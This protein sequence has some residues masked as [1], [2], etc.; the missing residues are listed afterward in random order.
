MVKDVYSEKEVAFAP[1]F[2]AKKTK[3]HCVPVGIG[4]CFWCFCYMEDLLGRVFGDNSEITI[5]TNTCLYNF[6]PLKP[7]SYS[8]TGVYR[9]L[10]YFSYFWSK[11][12]LWVLKQ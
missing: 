9:G 10:H 7:H 1:I 12:R 4:M 8:K 6:D 11:H 3:S 2:N 5:I